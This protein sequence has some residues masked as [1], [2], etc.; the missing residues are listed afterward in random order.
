MEPV[1]ILGG[2]HVKDVA[3]GMCIDVMAML[4][5]YRVVI[6]PR[7]HQ[8]LVHGWCYYGHGV[9]ANGVP[10]NMVT[11]LVAALAAAMVWDG[12]GEP[13]GYDKRAF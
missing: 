4:Y 9:D 2:W 10:R 3:D 7:G 1:P 8:T 12:V 5:N 13:D 6:G 11:S